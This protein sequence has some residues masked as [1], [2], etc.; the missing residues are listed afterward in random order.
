MNSA[1]EFIPIFSKSYIYNILVFKFA[2]PRRYVK[3]FLACELICFHVCS[4]G[5]PAPFATSYMV[6]REDKRTNDRTM[7]PT[8]KNNEAASYKGPV[9]TE[10][11]KVEGLMSFI[12]M[13]LTCFEVYFT[14][15]MCQVL[16]HCRVVH[17]LCSF[18]SRALHK[19]FKSRV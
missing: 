2:S 8:P 12:A 11:F 9:K 18:T 13:Q 5:R 15:F 16:L 19:P 17:V 14:S 4:L 3:S 1:C 7:I 10:L 6:G